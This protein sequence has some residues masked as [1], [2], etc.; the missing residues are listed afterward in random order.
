METLEK[1]QN[2]IVAIVII[3]F[4]LIAHFALAQSL[5]GDSKHSVIYPTPLK[6]VE[7]LDSTTSSNYLIY[8]VDKTIQVFIPENSSSLN[9]EIFNF[10][11]QCI[12][13]QNGKI[14]LNDIPVKITG[15]Y[16][17]KLSNSNYSLSKKLFIK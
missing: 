16:L 17:I 10:L 15:Y 11:G 13:K 1:N 7:H 6:T 3:I 12:W 14:G 4:A 5:K 8:G 2:L 9:I